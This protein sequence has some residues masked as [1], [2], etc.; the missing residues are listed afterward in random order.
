M[1]HPSPAPLRLLLLEDSPDDAELLLHELKRG[2]V[3]VQS[4][5]VIT[6][7]D[8]VAALELRPGAILSDYRLPGWDGLEA[9][10]LVRERELDTPFIIVSGT[11][12]EE[13]GVEAMRNGADDYLLKDRLTR[14]PA[15]L[16]QAL[17]RKRLRDKERAVAAALAE[18]EMGLRRAQQVA[19]LAHVVTGPGGRFES[20]AESLPALAGVDAA[21]LPRTTRAWLALLHPEDQPA[22]R[23]ACLEAAATRKRKLV[24]YRLLRP[25]GEIHV[26]QVMEPLPDG[27]DVEGARRWF[28]TVQDVTEQKHAEE[29]IRRLNRIHAVLSAINAAIVRITDREELFAEACRIAIGSGGFVM[30]WIGL[31]DRAAGVVRPVASAGDVGDFLDRAPLALSGE[32]VGALGRAGRAVGE[33]RPMV[34]NDLEQV[35]LH[36][37]CEELTERGIHSQGIFPLITRGEAVGV[38]ALYAAAADA[39]DAEEIELLRQLAADISLAKEF[40]RTTRELHSLAYY[41]ALTGLANGSLFRERLT[42]TIRAAKSGGESLAIC[43]LDVANFKGFNDSYGRQVGDLL[44]GEIGQRLV[45]YSDAPE[46]VARI[47]ADRF[48]VVLDGVRSEAEVARRMEESGRT[49]FGEPFRMGELELGLSARIG[50]ALFPADGVDAEMLVQHAESALKRAKAEGERY[51]FY[52]DQMTA[53]VAERLALEGELRRAVEKEEFVL[54]YQ[55][56]VDLATRET[57]AVEALLRWQSPSRG[58]VPP[59]QFIPLLE[60][61]GLILQVGRWALGCAAR[62]H[63][64]WAK[65]GAAPP[66]IAVNVSAYQLREKD[67]VASLKSALAEGI[68]PPGIDL[69][70]TESLIMQDLEATIG[71]LK[72]ARALG[73]T[74]AIDD[75]GTGYSSLAYL[76][77]LPVGE[78][79]I[80]RSFVAGMLEDSSTMTVVQSTIS[81]AHSLRLKVVAEGVE[82][83]E[84]AKML[85]LLGC[86]LMQGYLISKPLPMPAM[87]ALLERDRAVS[88]GDS[89]SVAHNSD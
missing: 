12:G 30:A 26:R 33:L 13:I 58:L 41:D 49:C 37:T 8:F 83:E 28:N 6:R 67:F 16:L 47:G 52:T 35:P 88:S 73:C 84:Q 87:T 40:I 77:R 10:H 38:L 53:R 42:E 61:T 62:D 18:S 63:R 24:D 19:K 71:K 29:R 85:R 64:A 48:A 76:A 2:G 34:F 60:E 75:F 54:Y 44:L 11:I 65:A 17:E 50:I 45:Q 80:D 89:R 81:L 69:E 86:D 72:E 32:G 79:K 51:L 43:V 3:V 31:V 4:T 55:P 46:R 70:L 57:V 25:G 68:A 1:N 23:K 74:I 9:L 56:K 15:A 5:C 20:W 66:R 78:L 7:A 27:D 36:P 21:R 59:M 39:F 82:T 22:F 14:L